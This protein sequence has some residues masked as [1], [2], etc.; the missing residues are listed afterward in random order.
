MNFDIQSEGG[1]VYV[2]SCPE[3]IEWR[4]RGDL[5]DAF[6]EKVGEKKLEGLIIDL[7]NVTYINSAGLGAIFALH[8]HARDRGGKLAIARPQPSIRRL[9]DTVNVPKLIPVTETVDDAREMF[10]GPSLDESS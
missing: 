2:I 7:G 4:A 3:Q 10:T 1:G 6:A 9:L 5:P 8:Q